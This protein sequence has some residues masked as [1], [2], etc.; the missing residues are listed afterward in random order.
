MARMD[1]EYALSWVV[2]PLKQTLAIFAAIFR[3][4]IGYRRKNLWFLTGSKF[5]PLH[6][7]FEEF[8][9]MAKPLSFCAAYSLVRA[10]I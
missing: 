4:F 7:H 1:A 10:K 5:D 2:L 3:A 6:R 9:Y 8:Y